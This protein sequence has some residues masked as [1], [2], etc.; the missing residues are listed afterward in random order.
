MAATSGNLQPSNDYK[1]YGKD[2]PIVT[3]YPLLRSKILD[4][5]LSLPQSANEGQS[6]RNVAV[7][8]ISELVLKSMDEADDLFLVFY[9]SLFRVVGMS[10][11]DPKQERLIHFLLALQRKTSNKPVCLI[12]YKLAYSL[13]RTP[14]N[15]T[16]HSFLIYD[17]RFFHFPFRFPP[18]DIFMPQAQNG[19]M[20]GVEENRVSF[21][22]FES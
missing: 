20:V 21:Q 14:S 9:E 8:E 2:S 19:R 6:I 15:P 18:P 16:F 1:N 12:S 10:Y 5:F 13:Y 17:S 3:P 22:S 4:I 7:N 11:I